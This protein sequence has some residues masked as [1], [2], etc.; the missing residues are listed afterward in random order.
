MLSAVISAFLYLS[1][2][3]AMY[4]SDEDAVEATDAPTAARSGAVGHEA[5]PRT[6]VRVRGV[7]GIFPGPITNL[8]QHAVPH[9]IAVPTPN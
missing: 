6:G 5:R 8:A 7:G 2:V 4:G 1:I 9:I 3:I